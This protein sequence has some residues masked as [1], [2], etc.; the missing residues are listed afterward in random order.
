[1]NI[2][3]YPIWYI[4]IYISNWIIYTYIYLYIYIYIYV[5]MYM[6]SVF[7]VYCNIVATHT[8]DGHTGF[9]FTWSFP[10]IVTMP[11]VLLVETAN[12]IMNMI[13][14]INKEPRAI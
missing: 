3:Y 13:Q 4:Y 5:C 6:N 14:V 12:A 8:Y 11:D 1:M 2:F 7:F 10:A 9:T